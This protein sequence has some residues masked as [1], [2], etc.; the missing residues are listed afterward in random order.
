MTENFDLA[1][2]NAPAFDDVQN[3]LLNPERRALETNQLLVLA[4]DIEKQSVIDAFVV[5]VFVDGVV[6]ILQIKCL[7]FSHAVCRV[8]K[9][10]RLFG[11]H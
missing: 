3:K 6:G 7:R 11:E 1:F 4:E 9:F 8:G 5:A 10:L 2:F